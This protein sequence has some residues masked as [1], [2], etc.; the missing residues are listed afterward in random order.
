MAPISRLL[1]QRD[2]LAACIQANS[3]CVAAHPKD[4]VLCAV[5]TGLTAQA[6]RYHGRVVRALVEAR[7]GFTGTWTP[8]AFLGPN[9]SGPAI[10]IIISDSARQREFAAKER[11]AA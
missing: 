9:G 5:L 8:S 2:R 3:E 4:T 7:Q 10:D 6:V 11:I 1:D